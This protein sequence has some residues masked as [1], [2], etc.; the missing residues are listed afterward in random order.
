MYEYIR[1]IK[2][3]HSK[4][5]EPLCSFSG[6]EKVLATVNVAR[7]GLTFEF[8]GSRKGARNER[9]VASPVQR[10]VLSLVDR[11]QPETNFPSIIAKT[12]DCLHQR[13]ARPDRLVEHRTGAGISSAL[14]R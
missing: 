13:L 6:I 8:T 9:T 11:F 12:N 10:F 4:P 1:Q 3:G 14:N 7:G 2:S 5:D